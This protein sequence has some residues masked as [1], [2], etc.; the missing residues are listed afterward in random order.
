MKKYFLAGL[1]V[2]FAVACS[3]A[4][5]NKIDATDAQNV[6]QGEGIVLVV[7]TLQS[8]IGWT[9]RKPAGHHVGTLGVKSGELTING[10]KLVAG[11]FVLDMNKIINTDIADA[12]MNGQLVGHLKSADF[13]DVAKFPEG[14]FEITSVEELQNDS[15]S[16]KISGNLKLKNVEKNISFGANISK[17]GN[18]YKAVSVPFT[19]DRTQWGITYQSKN[20]FKDLKDSFIN[21]NIEIQLTIVANAK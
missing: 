18:S 19:I 6:A 13:F 16:H 2:V 8:S 14:K 11:T 21:D 4:P 17:E 3:N 12:T 10:D 1:A 7:D 15:I 9:G 5:K 20:I